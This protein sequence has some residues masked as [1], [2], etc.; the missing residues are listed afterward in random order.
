MQRFLSRLSLSILIVLVGLLVLTVPHVGATG[1]AQQ[2]T[3]AIPTVTGTPA[4]P[5]VSVNLDQEQINVRDGPG[6][7]YN[8]VGVLIAGENV[9]ALG[10]SVAGL[11]I[12]VV[13]PGVEGGVAWV[14]APLVSFVVSGDLPIVEA[15]PTPAP[16]VTPTINPTYA[17][18][19][20]IDVPAT[21]LPTFTPPQPLVIPTFVPEQNAPNIP[22]NFPIGLPII[23]LGVFGI[24]GSLFSF[25]RGR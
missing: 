3:V 19:F 5:T 20:V 25:L 7:N 12:Q 24:L 21:R 9:P 13:Y 11:W 10:R 8:K 1:L 22:F 14:Y 2:P 18:Q 16:L 6:T 23:V 15:P 17:A 4:G